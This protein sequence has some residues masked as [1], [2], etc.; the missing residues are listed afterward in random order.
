MP[1]PTDIERRFMRALASNRKGDKPGA[2]AT[3]E[4]ILA[5]Q[6]DHADSL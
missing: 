2:R 6:P 4:E 1:T 3:L 5:E